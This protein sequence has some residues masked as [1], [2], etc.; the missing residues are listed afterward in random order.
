MTIFTNFQ[1][2]KYLTPNAWGHPLLSDDNRELTYN[3]DN[4]SADAQTLAENAIS[5][6]AHAANINFVRTSSSTADL[7]F[8]GEVS[9]DLGGVRI[10]D[11]HRFGC[12]NIESGVAGGSSGG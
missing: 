11:S 10:V 9:R 3:I 12:V 2:A 5:V 8:N 4:L 7:R 1:I 6:W